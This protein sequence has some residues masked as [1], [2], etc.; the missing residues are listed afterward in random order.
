ME[1]NR[2]DVLRVMAGV[3]GFLAVTRE[4]RS[5]PSPSKSATVH[6]SYRGKM[7]YLT[8]G[9]GETGREWFH[10]TIQPDGTRTM[11][12][13]CEMDDDQLLRDVVLTVD[14]AWYP[15]DAFVRLTVAAKPVGSSWF[16][17][18]KNTAECQG[19]T[20]QEGRVTQHFATEG[21]I[22]FFGAHQLHGDAWACATL[23]R[24]KDLTP[25]VP[26]LNFSSSHLPNGGSGP[27][28]VPT[29]ADFIRKQYVG[30]ERVEVTA[31]Q[32][33]TEHFQFFV[34]DY[35]PID[36]WTLGTD[37]IPVRLR[38][39]LLKQDYELVELEGDPA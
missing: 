11:R 13:T 31:G 10:V 32:F 14:N 15:V 36:V 19:F 34:A 26:D 4:T 33:D 6:R 7:R 3:T 18:T 2:R 20:S 5:A 9:I 16:Y 38:W 23:A 28:L 12:A 8:D 22:G 29:P 17:F 25:T 21:R 35:P 37:F 30:R 27:T 39:D 1:T 24:D